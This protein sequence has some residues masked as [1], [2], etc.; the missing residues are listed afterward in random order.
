M[1]I[2]QWEAHHC[3]KTHH[4]IILI[5]ECANYLLNKKYETKEF[6]QKKV[7]NDTLQSCKHTKI[8][9]IRAKNY[10]QPHNNHKA[11]LTVLS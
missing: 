10:S 6:H 1:K 4:Q 7:Q 11:T 3:Y 8:T 9:A 2:H 5:H